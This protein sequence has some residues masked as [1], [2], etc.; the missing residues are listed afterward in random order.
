MVPTT[1]TTTTT[2]STTTTTTTTEAITTTTNKTKSINDRGS[3]QDSNDIASGDAPA[4]SNTESKKLQT[5]GVTGS[6]GNGDPNDG[7]RADSA[8]SVILGLCGTILL[9]SLT[10]QYV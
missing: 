1:T 3:F 8:K 5:A 10:S 7:Y 6:G 2:T 9:F 4:S